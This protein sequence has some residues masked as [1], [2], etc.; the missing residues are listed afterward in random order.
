MYNFKIAEFAY[1]GNSDPVRY[2]SCLSMYFLYGLK[3]E[4][5]LIN[6][7]DQLLVEFCWNSF[8]LYSDAQNNFKILDFLGLGHEINSFWNTK[9]FP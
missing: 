7:Q 2:R 9:N 3:L 6:L 4:N 8:R 1:W 5:F